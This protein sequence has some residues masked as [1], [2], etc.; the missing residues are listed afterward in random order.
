MAIEVSCPSCAGQFRVPDTAA[1]KK[2]RC[3]KCKGAMEVPAAPSRSPPTAVETQ[4]TP[5]RWFLKTED[6]EDFGPAA[7]AELDEWKAE[8]R[9]TVDCQLLRE[10]SDQWQ[11][12]EDLYP[13]LHSTPAAAEPGRGGPARSL[14]T[15]PSKATARPVAAPIECGPTSS[16]SRRVAAMLG[17]FLGPLGTHRFYLGYWVLG[18]LML[19]TG[20]GCGIWSLIDAVLVFL[21]KVPDADGRR[22]S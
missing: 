19:A 20:G 3:P 8:G 6:G 7:R 18:L 4:P 9:I 11:W 16:R 12:A 13:D 2:I 15:T 21:G 14:A 10:G 17:V 22:L 1:K 5:E